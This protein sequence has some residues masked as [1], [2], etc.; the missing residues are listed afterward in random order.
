MSGT[1]FDVGTTV[2]IISLSQTG[3]VAQVDDEPDGTGEY[4]H[5][6]DV[7]AVAPQKVPGSDLQL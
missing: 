4:W 7:G 2:T 1:R 3:I 5:S 6:I